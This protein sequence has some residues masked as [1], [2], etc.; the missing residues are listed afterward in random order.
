MQTFTIIF[1]S[2]TIINIYVSKAKI[3]ILFIW[4]Y[5]WFATVFSHVSKARIVTYRISIKLLHN[6]LLHSLHLSNWRFAHIQFNEHN[7]QHNL[8]CSYINED[9][10]SFENI[11]LLQCGVTE[12]IDNHLRFF[13]GYQEIAFPNGRQSVRDSLPGSVSYNCVSL[14]SCHYVSHQ[15]GKPINIII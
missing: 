12:H 10:P 8:N 5:S 11:V 15:Y 4:N 1:N 2:H 7:F 9:L 6:I 3:I 13:Y 14:V